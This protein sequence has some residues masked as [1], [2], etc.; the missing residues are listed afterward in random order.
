VLNADV[1]SDIVLVLLNLQFN[2]GQI[3]LRCE[4]G[5][6]LFLNLDRDALLT[7]VIYIG[8]AKAG[9]QILQASSVCWEV[10]HR[11]ARHILISV[12]FVLLLD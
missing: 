6:I 4:G 2:G 3:L 8:G 1:F 5:V 12:V 7:G 10:F 9:C 11:Q